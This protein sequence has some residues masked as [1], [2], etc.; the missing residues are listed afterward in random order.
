MY[1]TWNISKVKCYVKEGVDSEPLVCTLC[2]M[3]F[4]KVFTPTV[5]YRFIAA[6]LAFGQE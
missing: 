5:L 4:H 2:P 3:S 6:G 1:S